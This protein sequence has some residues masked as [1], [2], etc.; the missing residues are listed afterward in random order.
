MY[1]CFTSMCVY[2]VCALREE[3][4]RGHQFLRMARCVLNRRAG[5]SAP[6]C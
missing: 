5:S 1:E 6:G 4:R 2:F 3:A